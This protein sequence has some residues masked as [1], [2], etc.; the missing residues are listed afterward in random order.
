VFDEHVGHVLFA[1][2]EVEGE[3]SV[4]VAGEELHAGGFDWS[5][6]ET[7]LAG[8][9]LPEGGG[10]GLLDFGVGRKV[11]EGEDVVGGETEDGFG[12]DGAGELAGAED[13][14]VEGLGGFVVGHD[15][16]AG[17]R[18]GSNEEG[19]IEGAGG[20]GEARDTSA[21]RASAEM[22]AYTL[23]GFRMLHVCEEL[24]DEGKNHA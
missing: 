21:P 8:G 24:A 7:G 11:F 1:D 13:G 19:K 16:D 14:G 2:P 6:D 4:V 22:A 23:E 10:A 17:G 12:G 3:G 9:D 5:D 18:G 15:D 20:E